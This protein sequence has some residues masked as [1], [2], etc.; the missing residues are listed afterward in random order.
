M[1]DQNSHRSTHEE[2]LEV[3]VHKNVKFGNFDLTNTLQ[4]RTAAIYQ[5]LVLLQDVAQHEANPGHASR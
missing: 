3:H 1:V 4:E 5:V 2:M